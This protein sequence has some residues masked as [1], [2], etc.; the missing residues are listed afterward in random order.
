MH[1]ESE[2]RIRELN[3]KIFF[4]EPTPTKALG[5]MLVNNLFSCGG[6]DRS[7][8]TKE[9]LVQEFSAHMDPAQGCSR[10]LQDDFPVCREEQRN[11][12]SG[13]CGTKFTTKPLDDS[14]QLSS[15]FTG[16]SKLETFLCTEKSDSL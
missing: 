3:E 14:K 13:T 7:D 4:A 6:S 9:L 16:F 12:M 5:F 10:F 15:L 11:Q 2:K 1:P 8:P